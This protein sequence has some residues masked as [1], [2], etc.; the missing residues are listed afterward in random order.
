M[1]TRANHR[2]PKAGEIR[3]CKNGC[4][5]RLIRACHMTY[6]LAPD[7]SILDSPGMCHT[8]TIGPVAKLAPFLR[9]GKVGA[10]A[11]AALPLKPPITRTGPPIPIL[12]GSRTFK[13]TVTV[14][15]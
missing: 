13:P 14:G 15:R 1:R 10:K 3:L 11:R 12:P 5:M 2:W 9:G 8:Y 6:Y 7:D 4:G